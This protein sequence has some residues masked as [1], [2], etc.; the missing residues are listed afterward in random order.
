MRGPLLV[1]SVRERCSRTRR[2]LPPS[3]EA[4]PTER[5]RFVRQRGEGARRWGLGPVDLQS[6][7]EV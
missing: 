3:K 4:A 7:G 6:L 2:S 5:S 1:G